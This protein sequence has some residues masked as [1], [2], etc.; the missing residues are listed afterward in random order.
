MLTFWRTFYPTVE[1]GGLLD[2]EARMSAVVREVGA[3]EGVPVVDGANLIPPGRG[4]FVE[5]VHFT[6]VGARKLATLVANE[7]DREAASGII[8]A[9]APAAKR[10]AWTT[11]G[12]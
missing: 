1:E 8:A 4:N 3:Q 9:P 11:A 7:I 12:P 5:F 10:T 6:D 2:M